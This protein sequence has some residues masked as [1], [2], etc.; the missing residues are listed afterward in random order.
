M[1]GDRLDQLAARFLKDPTLFWQLCDSK[2]NTPAPD[3]LAACDLVG[4][5]VGPNN[6]MSTLFD[7]LI[8][9][10]WPRILGRTWSSLR[11]RRMADLP[12]AFSMTL[13]VAVT[14]AG[15]YDTVSDSRLAPLSNICVTAQAADG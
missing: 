2:N 7:I 11:R 12:G 14:D 15:D 6:R 4:I 8:G 3:A 13:P 5:P 10:S 1:A 9:G